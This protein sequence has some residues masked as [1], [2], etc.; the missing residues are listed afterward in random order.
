[1]ARAIERRRQAELLFRT[2]LYR[3]RGEHFWNDYRSEW[4]I[5]TR[6]D[7]DEDTG[8]VWA[9]EPR[10]MAFALSVAAATSQA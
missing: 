7:P 3:L 9:N 8:P 5:E 2:V 10:P 4:P 1:V 6:P